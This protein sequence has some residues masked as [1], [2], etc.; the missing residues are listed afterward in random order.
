MTVRSGTPIIPQS[1]FFKKGK[2][3][4]IFW[5]DDAGLQSAFQVLARSWEVV[6]GVVGA[7]AAT[8]VEDWVPRSQ[9]L[10]IL[11]ISFSA[12]ACLVNLV[13][14]DVLRSRWAPRAG[15]GEDYVGYVEMVSFFFCIRGAKCWVV[16]LRVCTEGFLWQPMDWIDGVHG[17]DGFS[18]LSW[19]RQGWSSE[20][21]TAVN[22]LSDC[23]WSTPSIQVGRNPT[24]LSNMG[25]KT[26]FG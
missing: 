7:G 2:K 15:A 5:R 10:A 20:G 9:S 8:A 3:L 1:A 21:V 14:L 13:G 4:R 12:F 18:F 17:G 26:G 25:E 22:W 23:W 24:F 11:W 6:T 19:S 16:R